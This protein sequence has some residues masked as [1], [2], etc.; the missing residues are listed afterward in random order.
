MVNPADLPIVEALEATAEKLLE[1]HLAATKEWFPHPHVP[2]TEAATTSRTTSGNPTAPHPAGGAQRPVR[3][4]PDRGQP[5]LL[6]PRHR[7]DVRPDGAWGEWVRRWTAEEGR[8][9]MV[10]NTYLQATRAIDPVELERARM[11]QVQTGA[12]PEPPTA[13]EGL[14]YVSLQELATR[15]THFNTGNILEGSGRSTDHAPVASDENLHFL[16]YRDALAAIIEID[17]SSAV[18]AIEK[19]TTDFAMPGLGIPGFNDHAKAIADAGH[20]RPRRS[21]TT[22]S[23][24]RSS[25]ATGRSSRSKDSRAEAEAVAR[26]AD[27]VHQPWSARSVLASRT[28]REERAPRTNRPPSDIRP[29]DSRHDRRSRGRVQFRPCRGSSPRIMSSPRSRSP[30][31]GAAPARLLG[32]DGIDGALL[33]TP[34]RSVHTVR[35]RFAIDVAHV[36]ADM[37][38]RSVVTMSPGPSA[39]GGGGRATSSRPRPVS[40]RRWGISPA[41]SSTSMEDVSGALVLI[42]TPIGNLGDLSPRAVDVL[43]GAALVFAEDTRRTGRFLAHAG[44]DRARSGHVDDHTEAEPST[45]SSELLA[46]RLARRAGLRCRDAGISDPGPAGRRGP[47][48]RLRGVDRPGPVAAVAAL[49]ASGLATDRF[50]FEGFLPRKGRERGR[51]LGELAV[52]PRTMVLFASHRTVVRPTCATLAEALGQRPSC[53]PRPRTDQAPRGIPSWDA[54]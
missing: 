8:H 15:I 26:T 29:R 52:E 49:V 27:Q 9:G 25:S 31:R 32:R 35:M 54:G 38:V 24:S 50:V 7:A 48:R 19:Q 18:M 53:D 3:Q 41:Y 16:F 51:R 4:C 13:A 22:R 14:A 46:A 6:L 39:G 20:L 44:I 34:A 17:P 45:R 37:V 5:A 23:C 2:W 36:D 30:T 12:V 43:T 11:I 47:R 1:R 40:L 42:A 33:I 28:L 10:L 21:T